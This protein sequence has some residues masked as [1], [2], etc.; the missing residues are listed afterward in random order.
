MTVRQKYKLKINE[1]NS[2]D[3]IHNTEVDYDPDQTLFPKMNKRAYI[4][5][6]EQ[7]A[8]ELLFDSGYD[9]VNLA[10][11]TLLEF[12]EKVAWFEEYEKKPA[13]A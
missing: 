8:Q 10:H 3:I 7:I 2:V 12:P 1:S 11:K 13:E 5:D 4:G 9:L 6:Y